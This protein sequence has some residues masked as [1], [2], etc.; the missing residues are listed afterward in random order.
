MLDEPSL[1]PG[2]GAGQGDLRHHPQ[3]QPRAEDQRAAGRQNATAA[4]DV[5]DH[6]YLIENGNIVMS[7]EAAVLKQ[8]PDIQEFYLGGGERVDYHNVKHYRRRKRWLA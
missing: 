4:L 2:A 8:N 5:A 3:D 6:A 1:Q 7:G